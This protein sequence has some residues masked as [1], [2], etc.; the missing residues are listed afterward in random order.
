MNVKRN[1]WFLFCFPSLVSNLSSFL[2]IR[3]SS[4]SALFLLRL[5]RKDFEQHEICMTDSKPGKPEKY[6]L[7]K[8]R[9]DATILSFY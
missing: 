7:S 1:L 6:T 4:S 9:A 2:V 3:L 5:K 8:E